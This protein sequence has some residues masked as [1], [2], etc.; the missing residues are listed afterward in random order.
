MARKRRWIDLSVSVHWFAFSRHANTRT[1][2]RRNGQSKYSVQWSA[3]WIIAANFARLI[4]S[5]PHDDVVSGGR[6]ENALAEDAFRLRYSQRAICIHNSGWSLIYSWISA[7]SASSV[8]RPGG[9][10]GDGAKR[11]IWS[12]GRVHL[13][14][15]KNMKIPLS[16]ALTD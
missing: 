3:E 7:F 8:R 12:N 13:L 6:F 9:S 4:A 2:T 1:H 5:S 11:K 14:I 10:G 15:Q 16:F